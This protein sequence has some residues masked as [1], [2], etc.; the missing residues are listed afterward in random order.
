MRRSLDVDLKKMRRRS[1]SS[2]ETVQRERVISLTEGLRPLHQESLSARD[3]RPIHHGRVRSGLRNG[4][5]RAVNCSSAENMCRGVAHPLR[6]VCNSLPNSC[7]FYHY[8]RYSNLS[9]DTRLK[10][11]GAEWSE[12]GRNSHK[13]LEKRWESHL[14]RM[15]KW[16]IRVCAITRGLLKQ[17]QAC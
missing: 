2:S 13:R 1:C 9:R 10:K 11:N 7:R 8:E 15:R 3:S 14:K 16:A 17:I 5:K 12:I 4:P 6:P